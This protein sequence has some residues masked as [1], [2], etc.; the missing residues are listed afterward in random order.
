MAKEP[1]KQP[2]TCSIDRDP[3]KFDWVARRWTEGYSA[4]AME[5]LSREVGLNMKRETIRKHLTLCL[6]TDKKGDEVVEAVKEV[7][8]S[9]EEVTPK[10]VS[11]DVATLVQQQVVEKL[12]EGE[13]RVTVQHGLQAQQLL[14][15]RA[16]RAK[17]RELAVTL[18]RLLHAPAP[19]PEAVQHRLMDGEDGANI[20]E[21]EAVEV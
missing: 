14:D 13:A 2:R 18:A 6:G 17:D 10:F 4:H 15:R 9:T 7:A 21:G 5:D 19:P 8:A 16:E 12:K 3:K 20:I 11:G 1:T